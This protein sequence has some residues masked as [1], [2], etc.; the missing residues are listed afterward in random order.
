MDWGCTAGVGTR[1]ASPNPDRLLWTAAAELAAG[2]TPGADD[3]DRCGLRSYG[4]RYPCLG[5]RLAD[6]TFVASERGWPHTWT[7]RHDV[8]LCYQGGA[9]SA[10]RLLAAPA[11]G[12]PGGEIR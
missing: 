5:R 3:P 4:E 8:L 7:V 2:H 1:Q 6:Q 9:V 10:A 12:L 11:A